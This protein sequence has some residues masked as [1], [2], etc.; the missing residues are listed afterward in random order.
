M[1]GGYERIGDAIICYGDV[2]IESYMADKVGD[3]H[4]IEGGCE[5]RGYE[6]HGS[7]IVLYPALYDEHLGAVGQL[8]FA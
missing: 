1:Y 7:G 5:R 3:V 2:C 6:H 4:F 8:R